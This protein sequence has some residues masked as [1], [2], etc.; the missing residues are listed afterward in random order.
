[1]QCLKTSRVET[2]IEFV[3]FPQPLSIE[4]I[5]F[6]HESTYKKLCLEPTK[7]VTKD[8]NDEEI[9]KNELT[10]PFRCIMR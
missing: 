2:L 8:K 10:C 1:M 3:T 4:I 6:F 5:L 7:H 9:V